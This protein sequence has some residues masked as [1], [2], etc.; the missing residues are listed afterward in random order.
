VPAGG[1]DGGTPAGQGPLGQVSRHFFLQMWL[2]QHFVWS[3]SLPNSL[4]DLVA[5]ALL[6]CT[7]VKSA[8]NIFSKGGVIIIILLIC[9]LQD[10]D[11]F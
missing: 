5:P 7:P 3:T 9:N 4:E 2:L 6:Q 1:P 10:S 8:Q 11:F